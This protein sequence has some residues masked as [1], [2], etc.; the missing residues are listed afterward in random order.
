MRRG[1][2]RSAFR[3]PLPAGIPRERPE[4][5]RRSPGE[6]MTDFFQSRPTRPFYLEQFFKFDL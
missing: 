3:W 2:V 5:V 1:V 6:R 4:L